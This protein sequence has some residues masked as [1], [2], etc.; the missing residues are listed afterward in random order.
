MNLRDKMEEIYS[1]TSLDKIPWNIR[2]P[3]KQ[4]VELIE[5]EK[6]VPCRAV[7]LG[8][9][10]GNYSIWLATKGFQV[11]GI[12]FSKK[13]VELACKK[14]E[15]ENVNCSFK[16]GDLTDKDFKAYTEYGFAYDWEVLHHVFPDERNTYIQN[17]VKILQKGSTYYTVCFSEEDPDFGEEGKYRKTPMDTTLYFSSEKEIEQLL[18]TQFEIKELTT[19][20]ISGKYGPHKAIIA[21]ASKK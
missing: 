15:Q 7:D 14:A 4:L 2:Q 1:N 9:G 21:L 12:D 16:V 6:I 13:A 17:V 20:E 11:T 8:C 10:A 19:T 3:P 5:S 18:E